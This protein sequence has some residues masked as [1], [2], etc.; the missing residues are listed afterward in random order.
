MGQLL[1]KMEG[2]F[3]IFRRKSAITFSS[4]LWFVWMKASQVVANDCGELD[5]KSELIIIKY[6]YVKGY[7][8]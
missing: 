6:M 7:V 3:E 1:I 8:V 5:N 4:Q 2:L